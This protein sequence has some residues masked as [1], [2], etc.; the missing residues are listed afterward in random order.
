VYQAPRGTQD[1]LPE[2]TPCWRHVE[3]VARH[4]AD[5][6]GYD[7]IRTPT[8]ED[9]GLFLRSVGGGTDIVDK[10]MYSFQDK[11][12]GD[13]TLR[14]E[15]TASI[16]RAY[17]EHGFASRPQ[18]VRLHSLIN[19]FRYDRPQR[20]RYREFHQWDCEA[21]GELD[22]QVDAELIALLWSFYSRLGLRNLTLHLNSI[23]DQH[24]RPAYLDTLRAYYQPLAGSLCADCGRRLETN[25]LR[26]LD[27]KNVQCQPAIE[28]A[29][30]LLNQLCAECAAHFTT[31]QR[32]L[33]DLDI[34][35]QLNP[36]LVRGLDYYTKTVFEVWPPRTG[37]QAALGGGGRYDGLVEEVGGRPTPGVG[38]ATGIERI[39]LTLK[40]Q[41]VEP[42]PGCTPLVYI[43]QVGEAARW[44]TARLAE[45]LRAR[46][47]PTVVGLA[48][49]SMRA[50]MRQA[51]NLGVAWA[52]I[53]GEDEL[54]AGQVMLKDMAS[55]AEDRLPADAVLARLSTGG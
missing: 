4:V 49:R 23:G 29:P 52:V 2:E 19:C 11:G 12:G 25:P 40:E 28:G 16:V 54:A 27:C 44:E 5:L 21:I 45:T 18:P 47:V 9:T 7:E 33:A 39:I 53:L 36:T 13:L 37:A 26:L 51:N 30:R 31:L 35:T 6:Y 20:G 32:Y 48:S 14:P 46:D 17:V 24:C 34:P 15:G 42:P 38:F 10:E 41:E 50:Q 55:G 3:Q 8:F 22:P 43:A 1:L